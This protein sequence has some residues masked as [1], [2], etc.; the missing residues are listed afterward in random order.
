MLDTL[1]LILPYS[2]PN[3]N[4]VRYVAFNTNLGLYS[5]KKTYI[6]LT[7]VC[8]PLIMLGLLLNEWLLLN[9]LGVYFI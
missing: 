4:H 9:K 5:M 1:R 2:N 8:L 3:P 7:W 6:N